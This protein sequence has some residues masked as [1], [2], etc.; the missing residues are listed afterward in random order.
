MSTSRVMPGKARMHACNQIGKSISAEGM[1]TTVTRKNSVASIFTNHAATQMAVRVKLLLNPYIFKE[2][3]SL[4]APF[5][6][7]T[8]LGSET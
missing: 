5:L 4:P 8:C 1:F 7:R 2:K 6:L 3:S